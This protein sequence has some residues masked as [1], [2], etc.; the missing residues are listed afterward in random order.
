M[1][2]IHSIQDMKMQA[3]QARA[4]G[5]TIGFVPTMGCLH[6]GH[7]SLVRHSQTTCDYTVVSIFIN[8][9]QFG[10]NEDLDNYPVELGKDRRKLETL[11]VDAL[12]LPSRMTIYPEG[13]KTFVTVEDITARLCGKSRPLLFDGVT[14][15]IIK[16]FNIVTPHRAFFGEKDRQQLQVIETMVRDLNLDVLIVGLPIIREPDGLAMSSRNLYLSAKQRSSALSLN[17]ALK[18]AE[19]LI[20]NGET[21]AEKIKETMR[22][23]INKEEH[24]EIDF[25]SVCDK[26]T[27][28]DKELVTDDVLIALAVQIGDARLIDNCLVEG[29]GCKGLC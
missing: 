18:T 17:R 11:G 5:K 26:E 27:F 28:M 25:I 19:N 22:E 15:I 4:A 2:K 16:L 3:S 1:E 14:T 24:T 9:A 10:E 20:Q 29:N 23:I 7:L 21:S 13:Y 6:E 8:P 12:F